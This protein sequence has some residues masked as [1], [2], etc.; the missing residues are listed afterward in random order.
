MEFIGKIIK[1]F[2][3]M[4]LIL[5]LA[6]FAGTGVE[7]ASTTVL[8]KNA[9]TSFVRLATKNALVSIQT[10]EQYGNDY[11]SGINKAND[12][13]QIKKEKVDYEAYLDTLFG[14]MKKIQ[15][16]TK[17]GSLTRTQAGK[18]LGTIQAFLKANR[19]STGDDMFRPIQFGMTYVSETRF[20]EAFEEYLSRLVESNYGQ[21]ENNCSDIV[22]DSCEYRINGP[23]VQMISTDAE[24]KAMYEYLYGIDKASAV[25]KKWSELGIG[26]YSLNFFVYYDISVT[27]HWSSALKGFATRE[28]FLSKFGVPSSSFDSNGALLATAPDITYEYRYVLTN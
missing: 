18:N 19:T 7:Y 17:T 6:C 3:F 20:K 1:K 22:I 2:T 10:T 16:S 15:G 27:V 23:Y 14:Q 26:D 11:A 8:R 21:Y 13:D 25:F 12:S 9:M 4:I 5:V 28:G 24:S